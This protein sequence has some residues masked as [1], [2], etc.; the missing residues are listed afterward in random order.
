M[1]SFRTNNDALTC[2]LEAQHEFDML[3]EGRTDGGRINVKF[4]IHRGPAILVNLNGRI[5]YFGSTVNRAA[6]IQDTA[7]PNEVV[8][9]TEVRADCD[10]AESLMH[11]RGG[12][13]CE[14]LIMLK[15]IETGQTVFRF[16]T[17]NDW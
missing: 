15:G 7:A 2:S 10:V 17:G 5:D 13:L 6:R 3:N 14:E 1:A 8:F 16:G 12:D 9:S 4:G 11:D